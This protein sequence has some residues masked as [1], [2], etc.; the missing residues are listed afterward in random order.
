[1]NW[2]FKKLWKP[3]PNELVNDLLDK[4]LKISEKEKHTKDTICGLKKKR[5]T[6]IESKYYLNFFDINGNNLTYDNM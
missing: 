5:E 4:R 1:M 3:N 2:N 6:K